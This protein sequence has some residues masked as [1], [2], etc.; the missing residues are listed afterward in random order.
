MGVLELPGQDQ[1]HVPVEAVEVGV[2]VVLEGEDV[3]AIGED[4]VD[5]EEGLG[6]PVGAA[7]ED[8][9]ASGGAQAQKIDGG[10]AGAVP[11]VVMAFGP[12]AAIGAAS[13]HIIAGGAVAGYRD[14]LLEE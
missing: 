6:L 8:V 1:H 4:G 7:G 11:V 10:V 14:K 12:S 13:E 5:V 2:V 9:D 3:S